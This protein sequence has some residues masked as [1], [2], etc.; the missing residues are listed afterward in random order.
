MM[1]KEVQMVEALPTIDIFSEN[2]PYQN[3]KCNICLTHVYENPL[4]SCHLPCN[5]GHMFHIVFM[6]E[7]FK[8]IAYINDETCELRRKFIREKNSY[9]RDPDDNKHGNFTFQVNMFVDV[10]ESL[11][12]K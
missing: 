1:G 10:V 11:K 9:K 5:K 12:D 6:K 7:W 2:H 8:I 4:E 3:V